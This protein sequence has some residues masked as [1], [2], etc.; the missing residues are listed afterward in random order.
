[1]IEEAVTVS[2][3]YIAPKAEPTQ[4][5]TKDFTPRVET[6]TPRE[7]LPREKSR[8]PVRTEVRE[9][10]DLLDRPAK[11]KMDRPIGHLPE[12]P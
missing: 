9:H 7:N 12:L 5:S 10:D 2:T 4:D 8:K 6:D 1:M 3:L 11:L